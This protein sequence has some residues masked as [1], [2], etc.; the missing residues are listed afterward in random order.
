MKRRAVIEH[1]IGEDRAAVYEGRRLVELHAHRSWKTTPRTGDS[2]QGRVTSIDASV[3]GA[4]V[5]LGTDATPALMPFAAQR[6]MPKLTEGQGVDVTVIRSQIGDKGATVRFVAEHDGA[7]PGRTASLSLKERLTATYPDI[8][9]DEAS[10]NAVDEA[11]EK[12][13]ALPGGGS[14]TMEQTQALLAIDVDKGS[15]PSAASAA[16]AAAKTIASQ[17]RLRGLGG[18]VVIDFP[19]LRQSKQRKTLEKTLDAG[20][21]TDPAITKFMP[22]SRFGVIEMTR[23]KPDL[24][25]DEILND[26]GPEPTVE[27]QALRALRRLTRE[28]KA[29]PGAKLTLRVPQAVLGWLDDAPFDWKTD[30]T[31][32]IGARYVLE[33]GNA[34]DVVA[35]R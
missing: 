26:G 24:S 18:L 27:T 34:I 35:D 20:F 19:N 8:I 5:D 16:N 1:A 31:A 25:L 32:K 11:V 28:A 10:V 3:A 9:F 12:H 30:L 4:W 14:I 29:A 22:L 13:V 7:K 6:G 15:A 23:S 2:Y 33:S 21:E 17:L